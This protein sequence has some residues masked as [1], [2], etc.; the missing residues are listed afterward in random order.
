MS[1]PLSTKALAELEAVEPLSRIRKLLVYILSSPANLSESVFSEGQ[2][3]SPFLYLN[4]MLLLLKLSLPSFQPFTW[5]APPL[6]RIISASC[7]L[8]KLLLS[9]LLHFKYL[10][11]SQIHPDTPMITLRSNMVPP[12]SI[13]WP[14]CEYPE[15]A[16]AVCVV[17]FTPV[18]LIIICRLR[19]LRAGPSYST[20]SSPKL[21]VSD[22]G[23][24]EEW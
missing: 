11:F 17:A 5:M 19:S 16:V 24:V 21:A 18:V 4:I 8:V 23:W 7:S 13:P 9:L 2:T 15:K 10:S 1:T 6:S 12:R 20:W 14:C 3:L 22:S